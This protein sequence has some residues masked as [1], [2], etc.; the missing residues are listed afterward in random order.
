MPLL[1]QY[2]TETRKDSNKTLLFPVKTVRQKAISERI[3]SKVKSFSNFIIYTKAS[4]ICLENF[5]IS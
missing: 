5:M 1:I 2:V 4:W 3:T